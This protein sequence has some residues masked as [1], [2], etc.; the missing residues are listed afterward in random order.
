M[1]VAVAAQLAVVRGAT[2]IETVTAQKDPITASG[3]ELAAAIRSGQTSSRDVV[4]AHITRLERVNPVLNAVVASRLEAAR[5]EADA[6]DARVASEP[7]DTL[8]PLLGVPCTIK[9]CF[10]VRGMPHTSG[11]VPRVGVIGNEDAVTVQRLRGAGAIVLG[12]TNVSELCMW[13]ETNNRVYGRT[14]NPYDPSRIVGGS[15]GGEGAIVGSGASPFGLGA[16]VGGSIRMPAFFNGVFGHKPS[17]GLVPNSGQFP[18][19]ENEALRYLTTGPLT[20]R[21][22]DLMPLLRVLAGPDGHDAGCEEMPLGDPD[23]VD[24][25]TLRVLHM[26]TDGRTRVHRE[27][28][29][30]QERGVSHL[31]GLGAT[32]V[33]EPL[34]E[35]RHGVE[36]WSAM[37]DGAGGQKFEI[38]LGHGQ[39]VRL[40]RQL[41]LWGLRRSP[42][43]L[44][45]L[46]L[47]A[48]ERLSGITAGQLTRFAAMGEELRLEL[49]RRLAGNAVML[50]PSFPEPAPRHYMPLLRPLRFGYTALLN[51]MQVP[52]TQV[53]MGLSRKGL[54]LGI[55]VVGAHGQ[56][57]RTIAVAR[58][59]ERGFGGWVMPDVETG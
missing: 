19:A 51:V 58:E 27:L 10:E 29:D 37:L 6:A 47:A 35:L 34:R 22:S 36:I 55:Q 53:P 39:P 45:A 2:M 5:F 18:I 54:P 44:P 48:L 42:H 30:A 26:P 57:H 3:V 31:E 50:Y 41:M 24:L 21:A 25:T 28:R 15:S 33:R 1:T 43:T 52:A 40:A 46:G 17:G 14:N 12:V 11:H 9:E 49:E 59:L 16:D 8:P 23:D 20:R 32:V 4:E 7:V 56:D 13:L 38:S